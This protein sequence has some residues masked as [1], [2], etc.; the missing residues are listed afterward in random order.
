MIYC[1]KTGL[2][3]GVNLTRRKSSKECIVC[4]YWYFNHRFK[5]KK[6][7]CNGYH[8]LIMMSPDFNNI[9]LISIKGHDYCC[10][11]HSVEILMQF[12]CYKILCLMIV[13][14]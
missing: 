4:H 10:I 11:I 5:F 8:D 3:E 12:L 13:D 6:P 1:S 14:L 2:T 7:V 9:A